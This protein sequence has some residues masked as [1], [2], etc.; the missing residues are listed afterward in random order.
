MEEEAGATESFQRRKNDAKL[1]RRNS[2][3]ADLGFIAA[4]K[5]SLLLRH[6]STA[7]LKFVATNARL[8]TFEPGSAVYEPG[9][10]SDHFYVVRSGRFFESGPHPNGGQR[11][12]RMH[13]GVGATFG[14]HELLFGLPRKTTVS[15]VADA[16]LDAADA[17]SSGNAGSATA[18]VCW[19]VPKRVFEAKIRVAPPPDKALLG[20]LQ[21]L[22]LFAKLGREEL[23]QLM[24]AAR[25]HRLDAGATVCSQGEPA[26]S[27]F[28]LREGEVEARQA[29]KA[30]AFPMRAPTVFG[31]SALFSDDGMRIRQAT[32]RCPDPAGDSAAG[33][34]GTAA[35]GGESTA[36]AGGESTV[37]GDDEQR[38]QAL[39]HGQAA[40]ISDDASTVALALSRSSSWRRR[41][42]R[43]LALVCR[44]G[45]SMPST[46]S[47]SSRSK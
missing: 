14:S 4:V 23:M 29:G 20:F 24:R 6:L 2:E 41:W 19:A 22:P 21:T 12:K 11:P 8:A 43:S 16:E 5:G 1:E 26:H 17:L 28:V 13:A 10:P 3:A 9:S 27:L 36:A 44:L 39:P 32:V 25:P 34:E 33:G 30:E 31:E 42:R 38:E 18:A 15:V 7:E 40:D 35:A 37:A 46:R 45:R 47:S